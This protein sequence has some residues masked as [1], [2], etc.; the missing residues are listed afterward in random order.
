MEMQP[1][2]LWPLT[3]SVT[4]DP[5]CKMERLHIESCFVMRMYMFKSL[6]TC[7]FLSGW[8]L[9]HVLGLSELLFRFF[10]DV[11]IVPATYPKCIGIIYCYVFFIFGL[12]QPMESS[13]SVGF[14][15]R[16]PWKNHHIISNFTKKKTLTYNIIYTSFYFMTYPLICNDCPI[17]SS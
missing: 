7:L 15:I 3:K 9:H 14:P 11:S 12:N 4:E 6:P 17:I 1:T 16:M 13:R 8:W 5:I 10:L 2:K